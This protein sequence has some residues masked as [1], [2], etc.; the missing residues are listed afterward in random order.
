MSARPGSHPGPGSPVEVHAGHGPGVGAGHL[1]RCLA[2]AEA[3]LDRGVPVHL[4]DDGHE[5][6]GSW[7]DRYRAA[8]ATVGAP[9]DAGAVGLIVIDDYAVNPASVAARRERAPLLLVDD[10]G[11]TGAFDADWILDQ[12]VG[13]RAAPYDGR[14]TSGL[15]LG[16]GY[17]LV[18][19]DV[20][21][22]I[23]SPRP[24]RTVQ[25]ARLLVATGGDPSAE[26][27]TA[28][29]AATVAIS[30]AHPDL[31]VTLLRGV[32]EVGRLLADVDLAISAAGSTCWDLCAHGIPAVVVA[33]APN[34]RPIAREIGLAGAAVDAGD[35]GPATAADLATAVEG[36][37]GDPARR[38]AIAARASSLVD[39]R[40]AGRVV[41]V[42]TGA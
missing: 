4:V 27:A 33:V 22:A 21:G 14:A 25:P 26:L 36:L 37:L 28:V 13:A 41:D 19:R 29:D 6:P 8:G 23:R 16:P 42:V 2:L 38:E 18:R 5:I 7:A 30:Q 24:D 12:N 40:G 10:H 39:G 35:L 3:F 9:K 17:A 11:S 20:A 31:E 32:V 15:L 1:G 34:Q